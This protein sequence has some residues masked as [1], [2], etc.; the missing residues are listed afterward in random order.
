MFRRPI[1]WRGKAISSVL[2]LVFIGIIVFATQAQKGLPG[3]TYTRV[4]AAFLSP[5]DNSP[6]VD[7]RVSD[8]DQN[9]R[10]LRLDV[11]LPSDT[12][13]TRDPYPAPGQADQD[14]RTP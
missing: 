6:A 7:A 2:V 1:P 4:T 8:G 13:P 12:S 11:L 9:G 10:W 5:A 3:R 14:G